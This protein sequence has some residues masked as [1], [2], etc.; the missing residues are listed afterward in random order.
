MAMAR[1]R[2]KSY[3]Q[4][5]ALGANVRRDY[6]E[7]KGKKAEKIVHDLAIK[8]FLTDWC[9]PNP[10][11]PTGRELCDL[12]VVF[13]DVVVIWQ[14][15]DIKVNKDGLYNKKE[16]DKNLRQLSGAQRQLFKLRTPIELRNPGRGKELFDP[17]TIR[18]IHLVSALLGEGEE[19]FSF[20]ENIKDR[21]VHVFTREFTQIVL[22]ELDTITDFLQYLRAKEAVVSQNK[23]LTLIGGEE[24]LLAYYLSNNRS[25]DKWENANT[26]VV[27]E[28]CW[29]RFRNGEVYKAKK[30]AD[31]VSHFWDGI[32]RDSN[33]TFMRGNSNI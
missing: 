18:E 21:A 28:G 9:Y 3:L 4:R 1:K 6:F 7:I 19:F 16:V 22:N 14:I 20:V 5:V 12:L 10:T 33:K 8:S 29:E 25:F 24:E 2:G 13:D 23:R 30:Q 26:I 27:D 32:L 15:K 17:Q 11:L 31:R